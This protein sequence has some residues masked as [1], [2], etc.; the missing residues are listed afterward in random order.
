M[1]DRDKSQDAA[2]Q[3]EYAR[4]L[5]QLL[6]LLEAVDRQITPE[7]V[8]QRFH[9][10]L[11]DIGDDGPP[12]P[13]ALVDGMAAMRDSKNSEGP[14]LTC[15]SAEWHAFMQRAPQDEFDDF[16]HFGVAIES[17]LEGARGPSAS[18]SSSAEPAFFLRAALREAA[19]ARSDAR[20]C[21]EDAHRCAEEMQDTA[22][23]KA[24]RIEA[25]AREKAARIEAEA[26]E[27]AER[28]ID[29]AHQAAARIEA[30]ARAEAEEI[31]ATARDHADGRWED[32]LPLLLAWEKIFF[33][34]ATPV[35]SNAGRHVLEVG[36]G[37]SALEAA[38]NSSELEKVIEQVAACDADR[39]LARVRPVLSHRLFASSVNEVLGRRLATM[40]DVSSLEDAERLIAALSARYGSQ[41]WRRRSRHQE[42]RID[43]TPWSMQTSFYPMD[44]AGKSW[45]QLGAR[46]LA[47]RSD[48]GGDLVK[49]VH[50]GA[51]WCTEVPPDS[52]IDLVFVGTA[53]QTIL[54]QC[55]HRLR[56]G[57]SPVPAPRPAK[58]FVITDAG[59]SAF[60]HAY[61][62]LA[63]NAL[64]VLAETAGP[65]AIAEFACRQVSDLE[66]RYA[67]TVAGGDLPGR[68]QALAEALSAD[69]YAASADPAPSEFPQLCEAETETFRRLL[70]TPVQRLATLGHGDGIC[71][72]HVPGVGK[73]ALLPGLSAQLSGSASEGADVG[74]QQV[75]G[76][77]TMYTTPWCGF[78]R[79][80]KRQLARDGIEVAEVDIERDEAAAEFVMSV[81]GG[82][83]TV[84]TVVFP[85]GTVLANPSAAQVKA[86]LAAMAKVEPGRVG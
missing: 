2:Q 33:D 47:N 77:L 82:R 14:V 37:G 1:N 80:L 19:K 81:N 45:A 72:T 51:P 27:K 23:E 12:V 35:P 55:K 64:R 44:L 29:E 58:V 54:V 83:Q 65:G 86:H 26:R 66:R 16:G 56:E 61:D 7:H 41:A 68:V 39:F 20:R 32:L 43:G 52:P 78:C 73:A 60:E 63:S 53:W 31:K 71:T 15:K 76:Q 74:D 4:E 79:N 25:E 40:A 62:G 5:A 18:P 49:F 59:R 70:G 85:D 57:R 9:E 6:N 75:S 13:P 69:G 17:F 38:F 30:T 46:E 10:L 34:G 50:H 21:V 22:L 84:P 48:F 42:R 11:D 28:T 3:S 8:A 36:W 67:P 24:A